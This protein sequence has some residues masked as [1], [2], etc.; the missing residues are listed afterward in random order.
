MILSWFS[1]DL[2]DFDCFITII[3]SQICYFPSKI[4][5]YL[6]PILSHPRSTIPRPSDISDAQSMLGLCTATVQL[7]CWNCKRYRFLFGTQNMAIKSWFVNYDSNDQI[8]HCDKKTIHF[9]KGRT[10]MYGTY[11]YHKFKPNVG[12]TIPMWEWGVILFS[13]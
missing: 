13:T 5:G 9:R 12:N 3:A 11:M 8:A 10:L 7:I 4:G 2:A 1:L 6:F